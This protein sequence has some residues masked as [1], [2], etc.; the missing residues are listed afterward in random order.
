[1]GRPLRTVKKYVWAKGRGGKCEKCG[2]YAVKPWRA[3]LLTGTVTAV[4]EGRRNGDL[5]P[6]R[7]VEGGPMVRKQSAFMKSEG[8]TR[9]TALSHASPL[10]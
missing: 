3:R 10:L 9:T 8:N 5:R 2:K 6:G 1:M 4:A 7:C